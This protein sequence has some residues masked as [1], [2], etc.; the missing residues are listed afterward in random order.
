MAYASID[1]GSNTFRLLI[2]EDSGT[3]RK[4]MAYDHRI[5]R[6]GEGL[7]HTGRLS[8]AG[9]QRDIETYN[10]FA[11]L[12]KQHGVTPEHTFAAATAAVREAENGREFCAR[13]KAET[14]IDIQI[15]CGEDEARLS[16]AGA[17]SVLDPETREDML[18]FDIGGGS[19]EFIRARNSLR[20]DDI[21]CKLGVVRLVV[22]FP[23]P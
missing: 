19:T 22:G 4:Q 21:S 1:S 23:A 5:T 13:V 3:K 17:S 14:D 9:M 11:T 8:E 2:A 6:L 12:L 16:L 10:D 15:I 20:I 18:L 7:H